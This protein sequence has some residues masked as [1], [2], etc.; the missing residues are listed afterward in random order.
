MALL[1]RFE[2]GSKDRATRLFE[3]RQENAAA[4]LTY[5]ELRVAPSG[6]GIAWLIDGDWRLASLK[7][8]RLAG[9]AAEDEEAWSEARRLKWS[10][11][12]LW[13][14]HD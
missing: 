14:A 6:D 9:L 7:D 8:A 5:D 13:T 1:V 11:V 12:I 3:F 2:K 10:D 4:Q